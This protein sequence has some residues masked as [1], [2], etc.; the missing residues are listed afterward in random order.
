MWRKAVHKKRKNESLTQN[1]LETVNLCDLVPCGFLCA[2]LI[3]PD[4]PSVPAG[5]VNKRHTRVGVSNAPG[6]VQEVSRNKPE[7]AV[8]SQLRDGQVCRISKAARKKRN[9][10]TNLVFKF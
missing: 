1:P 2:G 4:L 9:K 5:G 7:R 8:K 6:R 3:G 10:K